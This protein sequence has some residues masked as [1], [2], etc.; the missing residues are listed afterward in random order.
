MNREY[1]IVW[2]L[3]MVN[4]T[5]PSYDSYLWLVTSK[6]L[7]SLSL[8]FFFNSTR[9][10][11]PHALTPTVHSGDIHYCLNFTCVLAECMHLYE[12]RGR[13]SSQFPHC[14]W[15]IR[16]ELRS[17]SSKHLCHLSHFTSLRGYFFMIICCINL[18]LWVLLPLV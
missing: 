15:A 4:I 3:V 11:S 14:M 9:L 6:H 10:Y 18:F 16:I 2:T 5:L 7:F 12:V 1:D 8:F 17:S 13:L